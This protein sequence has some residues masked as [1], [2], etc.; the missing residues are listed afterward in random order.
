M[1]NFL[2]R[3]CV[4][5]I[6]AATAFAVPV[7]VIDLSTVAEQSNLI[8]AGR[9]A[10]SETVGNQSVVFGGETVAARLMRVTV[11][12]DRTLKGTTPGR[13]LSFEYVLPNQFIGYRSIVP[14]QYRI[15]F[16]VTAD[17]GG[18]RLT[19]P[20]AP[21]VI[22]VPETNLPRR[23]VVSDLAYELYS[24]VS[25]EGATLEE[26]QEAIFSLQNLKGQDSTDAAEKIFANNSGTLK[27]LAA[28]ILLQR[29]NLVALP[30]A[31]AAVTN[32]PTGVPGYVIDN[33]AYA[34]GFG[35]SDEKAVPTLAGLLR[36]QN[37]LI[38]RAA[39]KALWRT[40]SNM[41]EPAMVTALRD[42]DFE[43]RYFAVIGLA[44][45]TGADDWHPNQQ[46]FRENEAKYLQ[47]WNDWAISN[48][49]TQAQK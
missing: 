8:V 18:F 2:V 24:V 41:S 44:E 1:T 15:M 38:R 49:L 47:H 5:C 33:L 48:G 31:A 35:V 27:L 3:F 29:N 11:L 12:V 28:V 26:K 17:S 40:R 7:P 13:L 22:A 20:F 42:T 6:S 19:S 32:P 16:L 23:S 10:N 30:E 45:T 14:G 4:V 39:A 34:I 36:L 37:P 25:T 43:V 21:S 9:I 46:T